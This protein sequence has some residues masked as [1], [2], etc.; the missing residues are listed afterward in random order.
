MDVLINECEDNIDK[1]IDKILID[2][3]T[4]TILL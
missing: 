1:L 3:K 2:E 4:K